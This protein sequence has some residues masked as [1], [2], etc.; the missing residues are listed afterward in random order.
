MPYPAA[1]LS[2]LEGLQAVGGLTFSPG[3]LVEDAVATRERIDQLIGANAEHRD[4][5]EQLEREWDARA[6]DGSSG[7]AL[8]SADEL[9][10]EV[11]RFLRD[12]S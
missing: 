3:P 12:Q 6:D 1:A 11:E 7:N 4:M 5:V 2:L 9:A 10:A 8:P